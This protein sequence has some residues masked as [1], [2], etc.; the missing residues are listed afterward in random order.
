LAKTSA[1][2]SGWTGLGT[3]GSDVGLG[4]GV[5]VGSGVGVGG[6]SRIMG[7]HT[8]GEVAVGVAEGLSVGEAVGLTAG[9]FMTAGS[10]VAIALA[11]V[12]VEQ[13]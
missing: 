2:T 6:D 8:I 1:G 12:P 13:G 9:M 5:E 3:V 10:E 11:E 7:R 4:S